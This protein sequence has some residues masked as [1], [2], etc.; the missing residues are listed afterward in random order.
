MCVCVRVCV[1]RTSQPDQFKTV[2]ATDFK[3]NMHVPR[4]SPSMTP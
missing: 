1:Q 2:K 4:D 3:F